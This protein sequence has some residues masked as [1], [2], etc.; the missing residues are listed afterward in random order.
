L[1]IEDLEDLFNIYLPDL[2]KILIE[3]DDYLEPRKALLNWPSV[4][5]V[6]LLT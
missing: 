4:F 6:E 2:L 5:L 3:K 1:K